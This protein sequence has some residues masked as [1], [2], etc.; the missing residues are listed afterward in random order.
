MSEP[1]MKKQKTDAAPEEDVNDAPT[2]STLYLVH[3]GKKYR[4]DPKNIE[5]SAP[6]KTSYSRKVECSY[7]LAM[8]SGKI[9][10]VPIVL[11]TPI[12]LSRWGYSVYQHGQ[13]KSRESKASL[14]KSKA[15]LDVTFKDKESAFLATM[16]AWDARNLEALRDN[17]SSWMPNAGSDTSNGVL[18]YILG[19]FVKTPSKV[20]DSGE[21]V[22]FDPQIRLKIVTKESER[23]GQKVLVANV[24]CYDAES[25]KDSFNK[26]N[27]SKIGKNSEIRARVVFEAIYLTEKANPV[28]R[29]EQVQ[30]LSCEEGEK[31]FGFV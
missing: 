22:E 8:S 10:S 21:K 5:Y 7:R 27:I 13:G 25:S 15:S 4:F 12:C 26:I 30:L 3:A 9:K 11:Q 23:E 24:E 28:I 16:R 1:A 31:G 2:N 18:K 17:F 29:C 14:G 6:K 19:T 20:D